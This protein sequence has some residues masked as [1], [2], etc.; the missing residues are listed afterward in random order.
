MAGLKKVLLLILPV[1]VALAAHYHRQGSLVLPPQLAGP[2]EELWQQLRVHLP[3]QVPVATLHNRDSSAGK[4]AGGS[5][6]P[7]QV[8]VRRTP[9]PFLSW[10]STS[11]SSM[12]PC[13]ATHGNCWATGW[14]AAAQPLFAIAASILLSCWH[15]GTR[16]TTGL[17]DT[18]CGRLG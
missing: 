9:L 13:M 5:A 15:A 8:G 11:Q 10:D 16:V 1:L 14:S 17:A 7:A 3:F 12:R 4:Q 18:G 2:A 6:A